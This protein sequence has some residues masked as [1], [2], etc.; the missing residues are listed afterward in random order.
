MNIV[1][2]IGAALLVIPILAA[3]SI[4]ASARRSPDRKAIIALNLAGL[5]AFSC[6][7]PA[8]AWAVFGSRDR[9]LV[10]WLKERRLVPY[11]IA[12]PLVLAAV[13]AWV[14]LRIY[15]NLRA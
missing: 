6:W 14:M 1:G 12:V 2:V 11:A 4:V 5:L 8:L 10:A 3:P 7:A 13:G 15:T 9:S